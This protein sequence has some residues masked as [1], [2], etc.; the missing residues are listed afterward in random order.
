MQ[1]SYS[2]RELTAYIRRMFEGDNRLQGLWV[3]GEISGFKKAEPSGHCYFTLKDGKAQIDCAMWRSNAQ[4]MVKLP[5]DG[6][7]VIAHG[8]VTIYEERSKYQFYV[9]RL[10]PVGIGDLYRQ[11]ELLK[12]KL[13]AEG[14]FDGE[15]K[16][17]LPV[18]PKRIGVVTSP[19]AAAFQDVLN[20][21][22]RRYPL[23]EVILSPTL[24]QG[25]EAPAQIVRALERLNQRDDIDVILVC[26]GGGSIED[27][28]AFNDEAVARAIVASRVPVVSGVGHETDFTIA[29]FAADLRAPT[30]SAAAEIL[31]PDIDAMRDDLD[32]LSQTLDEALGYSLRRQRDNLDDQIR[33]LRQLSPIARV[34]TA[35]Q[36]LDDWQAHM[37][38]LQRGRLTLLRQRIEASDRALLA[39]S[40]QA[41]LERG[42]ALVSD[43]VTGKR[44][45]SARAADKN[46]T[47]QFHD[48]TI[49]AQVKH[50]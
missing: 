35:R 14:L 19:S 42:Y 49:E 43:S 10:R 40:P 50:D 24:V 23:V 41:I 26:R 48:G 32:R 15:R 11:F 33:L 2:V 45:K 25:V 7:A 12:Q 4:Q 27:L 31:T 22:S 20:V 36:R 29:D 16:R 5:K 17:P 39:A 38:S 3:E 21:L 13:E 37:T 6:D 8:N 46:I 28:W 44:I 34:R 18:Y 47:I 9:D 1:S 30:P